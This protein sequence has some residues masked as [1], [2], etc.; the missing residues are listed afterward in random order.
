[1]KAITRRL[2]ADVDLLSAGDL[3]FER[4]RLGLAGR[5]IAAR[6]PI[7]D[8]DAFLES[9][10]VDDDVGLPGCGPVAF[11]ALPFLPGAPAELIVPREIFGRADHGTPCHTPI[12][13]LHVTEPANHPLP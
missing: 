13:H 4:N 7:G 6:V 8:A 5:G 2:D 9:I 12:A 10:E 1:M 3:L 11:G